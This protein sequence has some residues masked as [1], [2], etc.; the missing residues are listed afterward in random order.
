MIHGTF[1]Q[2]T[3]VVLHSASTSPAGLVALP[4]S[5]PR[6][7]IAGLSDATP[8]VL[9]RYENVR[10]HLTHHVSK[11]AAPYPRML[12]TDY[13]P[14]SLHL[15]HH[16][17]QTPVDPALQSSQHDMFPNP[18]NSPVVKQGSYP[19]LPTNLARACNPYG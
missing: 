19:T 13:Q 2:R 5:G 12:R 16:D 10:D 18:V 6:L 7:S 17:V 9:H 1:F 15:T 3:P 8:K 11:A 4:N 14:D